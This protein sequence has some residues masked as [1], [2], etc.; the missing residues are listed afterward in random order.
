MLA[1]AGKL[2]LLICG[3]PG[4]AADFVNPVLVPQKLYYPMNDFLNSHSEIKNL[5]LDSS[6]SFSTL[7]DGDIVGVPAVYVP[8]SYTHLDVYKRQAQRSRYV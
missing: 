7:E 3:A 4:G 2:P 1:Q 8:V 5:C 6:V